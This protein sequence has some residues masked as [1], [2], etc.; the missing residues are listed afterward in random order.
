LRRLPRYERPHKLDFLGAALIMTASS[1]FMLALSMGGN[2]YPWGS[3]PILA[4]FATAFVLGTAFVIRLRTA[5]EPLIPLAILSDPA[6]GSVFNRLRK[7]S[8]QPAVRKAIPWFGGV[9]AIGALALTY[10]VLS[11]AP[12]RTLYGQLDDSQRASVVAALD[13]ASIPYKIDNGSGALTVNEEDL[14]RARMVVAS[15]GALAT[16][17][18]GVE[19]LDSLPLGASRTMEGERL[20]A[21]REREL[22]LTIKEIDGV[23]AVRVHLAQP[24]QSVF[25]RE[26][27]PPSASVMVRLAQGRQLSGAQVT[28]VAN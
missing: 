22:E 11:P 26:S 9:A 27:S 8:A 24:E 20:K 16:P 25:V 15:D 12:Q 3:T 21:A 5:P 17:Q 14:Y 13:K 6:G 2:T 10:S 7:L 4:L 28:A 23:E 1:S 19:L 18:S